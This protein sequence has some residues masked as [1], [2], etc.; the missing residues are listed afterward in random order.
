M[1]VKLDKAPWRLYNDKKIGQF[2]TILSVNKT[3]ILRGWAYF[4]P[5]FCLRT[6]GVRIFMEVI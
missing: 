2:V 1:E 4:A 6:L 5:T 3:R